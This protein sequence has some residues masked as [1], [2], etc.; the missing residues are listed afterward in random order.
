MSS[1]M[2]GLL[3]LRLVFFVLISGR[4]ALSLLEIRPF[5]AWHPADSA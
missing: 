3:A 5:G 2:S 1:G 4:E